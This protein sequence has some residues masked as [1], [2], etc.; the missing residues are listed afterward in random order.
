MEN[1]IWVLPQKWPSGGVTFHLMHEEFLKGAYKT[2]YMT[3]LGKYKTGNDV[4]D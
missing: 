3:V 1:K 2:K 4:Y